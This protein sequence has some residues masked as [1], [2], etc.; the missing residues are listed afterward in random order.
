MGFD[1]VGKGG[2]ESIGLIQTFFLVF[3]YCGHWIR[4]KNIQ[5]KNRRENPTP[6]KISLHLPSQVLR[7]RLRLG[8][9]VGG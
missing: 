9:S 1:E 7:R 2:W 5:L 3:G 4:E 8:T 6:F